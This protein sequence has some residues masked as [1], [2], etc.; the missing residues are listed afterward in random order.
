MSAPTWGEILAACENAGLGA[1]TLSTVSGRIDI[2]F[3]RLRFDSPIRVDDDASETPRRIRLG[4]NYYAT[5]LTHLKR[6][7]AVLASEC[8]QEDLYQL[9]ALARSARVA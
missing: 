2:D 3:A 6:H 4:S 5:D 7:L 1:V 9:R 8:D